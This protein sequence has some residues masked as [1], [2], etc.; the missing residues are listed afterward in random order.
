MLSRLAE[1]SQGKHAVEHAWRVMGC[2]TLS[3]HNA[4]FVAALAL[5]STPELAGSHGVEEAAHVARSMKSVLDE[6]QKMIAHLLLSKA[7]EGIPHPLSAEDL[8]GRM[9][10][11]GQSNRAVVY[12]AASGISV[13]EKIKVAVAQAKA[14][15]EFRRQE[16]YKQKADAAQ[17]RRQ[18]AQKKK[19][20]TAKRLGSIRK[21]H[22]KSLSSA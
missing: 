10:P 1:T 15:E 5:L 21:K 20:K 14:K 18:V 9:V 12:D 7:L 4:H 11:S 2:P 19:E 6:P 13:A 8:I 3:A 22:N 17:A 16:C